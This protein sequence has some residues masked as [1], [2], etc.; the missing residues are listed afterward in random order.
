M[1]RDNL[2]KEYSR[3]ESVYMLSISPKE[4]VF[5]VRW[6]MCS[7]IAHLKGTEVSG[8]VGGA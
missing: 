4:P 1:Q 7:N 8:L 3:S 5:K 2:A 6:L